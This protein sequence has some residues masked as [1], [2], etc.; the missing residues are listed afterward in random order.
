MLTIKNY[1]RAKTLDQAYELSQ[2]RSNVI[3][4]GMMW[5]KMQKKNIDTAID[6][7]DLGLN[8]I[9]ETENEI[10]IGAM[11]SLREL[12]TN[13]KLNEMTQGAFKEC[14]RHIVGV[15]FRNSATVGAS[16]YGRFGFSDVLTL[17]RV[18][19][20][21]VELYK[22]G[23]V[24]L[25]EFM[26][27]PRTQ[28]DVLVHIIIPKNKMKVVYLSQR[29]S[30]T[31]FPTVACAVSKIN[32]KYLCAVGARP[33]AAEVY[34]DDSVLKCGVNLDSAKEYAC[35]VCENMTFGSNMRA[36]AQYRKKVCTVLVRRALLQ[37]EGK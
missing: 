26:K 31:D 24:S 21:K 2:K 28:K 18:L 33:N 27:M 35:R 32:G 15:Q 3:L 22:L 1:I 20:A 7:C 5:L 12:E 8:N 36:S 23:T 16:I 11:V 17:F 37:M 9:E 25:D 19:N 4:G 34:I 30:K 10:K 29:N 6:L 14:T 13:K